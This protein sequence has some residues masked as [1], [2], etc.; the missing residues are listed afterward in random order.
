MKE[1]THLAWC[2]RC[3]WAKAAPSWHR[4]AR[5]PSMCGLATLMSPR[6]SLAHAAHAY[7]A[8]GGSPTVH[9]LYICNGCTAQIK[10]YYDTRYSKNTRYQNPLTFS[11]HYF[12]MERHQVTNVSVK[13]HPNGT[14]VLVQQP[15]RCLNV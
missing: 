5:G 12:P 10:L 13:L 2:R 3:A 9:I 11:P 7:P 8:N 15:Q 6:V 14:N 1:L 4:P